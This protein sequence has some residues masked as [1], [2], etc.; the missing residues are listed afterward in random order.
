MIYSILCWQCKINEHHKLLTV[1]L[2][3]FF[4]WLLTC[5]SSFTMSLCVMTSQTSVYEITKT[6]LLI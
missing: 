2:M 4:I 3:H 5:H 6:Y 1:I